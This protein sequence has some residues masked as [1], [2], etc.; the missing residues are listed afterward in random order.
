[1]NCLRATVRFEVE[2]NASANRD[3][4]QHTSH[5]TG[6]V[7]QACPWVLFSIPSGCKLKDRSEQVDCV[8]CRHFGLDCQKRSRAAVSFDC[9][10]RSH[11]LKTEGASAHLSSQPNLPIS[12][13]VYRKLAAFL[14]SIPTIRLLRRAC[15]RVRADEGVGADLLIECAV[16]DVLSEF[17]EQDGQVLIQYGPDDVRQKPAIRQ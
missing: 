4:T 7:C 1:M 3:A 11:N 14:A 9:L 17:A 16:E 10:Q 2:R 15:V 8:V 12:L 13:A 5:V 6:C